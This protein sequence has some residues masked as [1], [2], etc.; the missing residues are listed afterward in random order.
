MKKIEAFF[1]LIPPAGRKPRILLAAFLAGGFIIWA[2]LYQSGV[3][4]GPV[5][6][7]PGQAGPA[8]LASTLNWQTAEEQTLP[9]YYQAVG[10]VRSGNEADIITRLPASRIVAVKVRSGDTVKTGNILVQLEDD[11]LKA[12]VEAAEENLRSYESRL[13]FMRQE[14]ERINELKGRNVVTQQAFDESRSN[15]R[16]AEAQ[17]AMMSHN[18]ETARINLAFAAIRSPFDGIVSERMSDPG[19]LATPEA[20]LLRIFDSTKLELRLPVREGLVSK[21]TIGQALEAEIGALERP[22]RAVIAEIIPSVDPGS[23]T[24]Q[25][26]APL[27]GDSAGIMPGMFARCKI[28]VGEKKAVIIPDSAVRRVGQLEY[29]MVKGS[30]EAV[31]EVPVSTSTSESEG[32]LEVI[33]GLTAGQLFLLPTANDAD[34]APL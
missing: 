24:F 6:I 21:L 10:T 11:D 28:T 20:P 15:L 5:K 34:E 25:V 1:N 23:R 32:F 29:V 17:A 12:A 9:V 22:V 14:F 33:S 3:V 4:G 8:A 30:D 13:D 31:A 26:N 7:N 16:A 18:L 19:N 2:M 27:S